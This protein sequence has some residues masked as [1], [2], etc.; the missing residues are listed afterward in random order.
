M[1]RLAINSLI[2]LTALAAATHADA[3]DRS[4]YWRQKVSLFD[5]LPVSEDNIVM[6]GNS[7]TDGG[8]WAEL[9]GDSRVLNRGI[10]ADTIDGVAERLG[11]VTAG[12]PAKI[13]LLIGI[14]DVSHNLTPGEMSRG[15]AALIDSIHQQSPRTR[16]YLQSVMPVDNSFGRYRNLAGKEEVITQLNALLRQVAAD[17]GADWV[18]LW[19]AL[20]DRQGR[21]RQGFTNDGLHLTG[22]GYQAWVQALRPY[23]SNNDTVNNNDTQQ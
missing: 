22:A 13:F 5:T 6:L 16:V 19:P 11:Q 10:S 4:E 9:L 20:A 3:A 1:K 12:H 23:V 8:E 17:H 7:I 15:T 2:A 18:D 21:L 14:N